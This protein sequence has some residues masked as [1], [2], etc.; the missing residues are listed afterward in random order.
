VKVADDIKHRGIN[1]IIETNDQ[2]LRKHSRKPIE[3]RD[4]IDTLFGDVSKI[5]LFAR[6]TIPGWDHWGN[7]VNKFN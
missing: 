4:R 6:K 5:E 1:Q 7:E 2:G 3:A